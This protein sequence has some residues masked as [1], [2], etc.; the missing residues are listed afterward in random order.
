M[1]ATGRAGHALIAAELILVFILC[2]TALA[3][4]M[5]LAERMQQTVV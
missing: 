4:I 5:K 1:I 3:V 2:V